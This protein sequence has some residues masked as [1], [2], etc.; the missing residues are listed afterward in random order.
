VA[1]LKASVRD[2]LKAQ[3]FS[4]KDLAAIEAAGDDDDQDDDDDGGRRSSNGGG[5]GRVVVLEGAEAQGFLSKYFGDDDDQ[6]DDDDAGDDKPAPDDKPT[7]TGNRW[8]D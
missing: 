3:G 5:S 2:K 4:A 6:A 8:F 1:K 7:R